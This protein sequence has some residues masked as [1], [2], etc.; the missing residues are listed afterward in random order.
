[1]KFEEIVRAH[2]FMRTE[3]PPELWEAD[4]RDELFLPM[5]GE[6]IAMGLGRGNELADLTL[7]VSNTTVEP[8]EDPDEEDEWIQEGDYVAVTVKGPGT[9]A[10][11]RWRAGQGPTTGLL[12]NVGPAAE[13]AGAV[14]AY[15]RDLGAEGS[16]TVFLPRLEEP[17]TT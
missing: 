6:M 13:T 12:C 17:G 10:D 9:W 8:E 11:D 4:T 1:M 5:L 16:V 15:T 3:R 14:F 7:N 2:G